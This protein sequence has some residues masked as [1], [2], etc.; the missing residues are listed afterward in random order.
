MLLRFAMRPFTFQVLFNLKSPPPV[1]T[2]G[3]ADAFFAYIQVRVNCFWRVF[4]W[5]G[6]PATVE[7]GLH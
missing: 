2:F 6:K 3:A 4:A 5:P 1:R 7:L